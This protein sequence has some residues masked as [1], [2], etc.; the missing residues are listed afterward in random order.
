MRNLQLYRYV[1]AVARAGSIR[2]AAEQLAITPSALNRRIL[3]LEEEL[4]V[5]VFDRLSHGV[6][7][8]AAGELLIHMIRGQLAE[9]EQLKSR[10]ADLSGLRRGHV[11]IACSQALLPYFMP[12]QIA[13]YQSEFPLVTFRVQVMDGDAAENALL[14][15]DS[16]LAIVLEPLRRAESQTLLSV[17]QPI[18]ALMAKDHPIARS[19]GVRLDTC[20]EYPLALPTH[21]YSVRK[22]LDRYAELLSVRLE[23]AVE[24]DSYVLLRNFVQ[25]TQA[26]AF[27]L[28]IGV[29][30]ELVE[31][32]V[33]S[34]PLITPKAP[35]GSLQVAQLKGRTLSVAAA[36][37][38]QQLIE[39]LVALSEGPP[40]TTPQH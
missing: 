31:G 14:D 28:R 34:V 2:Q 38:G 40:R 16:D 6:R 17:P 23:S 25:R 37:F 29:P 30:P 20:L 1:D 11:S 8:S 4:G 32:D 27:E 3:A 13:Q 33:C 24:A 21:A 18:Y 35:G 19:G 12:E 9:V 26:I 39:V 7:L 36:R 22:I 5:P 10:I 15:F